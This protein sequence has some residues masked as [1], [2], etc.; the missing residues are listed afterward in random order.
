MKV[1]KT[2]IKKLE[3]II[4]RLQNERN[5]FYKQPIHDI[6]VYLLITLVFF[7]PIEVVLYQSTFFGHF[8]YSLWVLYIV[9]FYFE[10]LIC[11]PKNYYQSIV[12]VNNSWKSMWKTGTQ[13]L[14][15]TPKWPFSW[16]R[17]CLVIWQTS[18]TWTLKIKTWMVYFQEVCFAYSEL[19][20]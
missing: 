3:K 13:S 6:S 18:S 17:T 16:R 4:E 7:L 10:Q 5:F 2:Q 15:N 14:Q 9:L 20:W 11:R 19:Y 12:C 8:W 1:R